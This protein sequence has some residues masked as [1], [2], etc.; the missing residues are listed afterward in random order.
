MNA[1][2][3][4]L[5]TSLAATGCATE[6]TQTGTVVG[7]F[8]GKSPMVVVWNLYELTPEGAIPLLRTEVSPRPADEV[9]ALNAA[10]VL[11]LDHNAELVYFRT[12]VIGADWGKDRCD[13]RPWQEWGVARGNAVL[14]SDVVHV[15]PYGTPRVVWFTGDMLSADIRDMS[16]EQFI[17][18]AGPSRLF[19]TARWYDVRDEDAMMASYEDRWRTLPLP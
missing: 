5:L 15:I 6:V 11:Y 12:E 3:A 16:V 19:V 13:P 9:G 7:L 18:I 10:C 17:A 8:H 4:V 1:V 2:Q 14:G